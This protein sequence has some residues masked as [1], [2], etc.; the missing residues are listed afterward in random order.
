MIYK[1]TEKQTAVTD[2]TLDCMQ[3]NVYLDILMYRLI[4]GKVPS[5]VF[6]EVFMVIKY[7]ST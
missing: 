2:L 7:I 1:G 5:K 6:C 3:V 4:K